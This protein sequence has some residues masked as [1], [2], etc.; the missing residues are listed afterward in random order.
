[1]QAGKDF[2]GNIIWD[3]NGGEALYHEVQYRTLVTPWG[4]P[5]FSTQENATGK[6]VQIGHR[7]K[8]KFEKNKAGEGHHREG[9]CDIAYMKGIVNVENELIALASKLGII[10]GAGAWY[11]YDGKK[12]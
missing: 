7:V 1:R 12:F 2:H 11:N 10:Q 5:V 4:E 8:F 6:P 9:F 3:T